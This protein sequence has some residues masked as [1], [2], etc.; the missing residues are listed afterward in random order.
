VCRA[1]WAI[2]LSPF[3]TVQGPGGVAFALDE[4]SHPAGGV[5]KGP[6]GGWEVGGVNVFAEEFIQAA[7]VWVDWSRVP[8]GDLPGPPVRPGDR[9]HLLGDDEDLDDLPAEDVGPD[10]HDPDEMIRY[11]HFESESGAEDEEFEETMSQ[12]LDFD[13]AWLTAGGGGVRRVAESIRDHRDF[14][15]LGVLADAL[16]EAGCDNPLLLWHCRLPRAAHARGSWVVNFLLK[17]AAG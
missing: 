1:E 4:D 17:Q 10:S 9:V 5:D 6:H 8:L 11:G 13:P 16:E 7:R 12:L 2:N 14:S 3:I 15:S